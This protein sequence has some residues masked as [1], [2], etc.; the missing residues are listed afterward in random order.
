[1]PRCSFA[2]LSE[3]REDE[4]VRQIDRLV[5]LELAERWMQGGVGSQSVNITYAVL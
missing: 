2:G 5:G 3:V 1:M 4:V